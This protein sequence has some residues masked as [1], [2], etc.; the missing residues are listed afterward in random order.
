MHE[1]PASLPLVGMAVIHVGD[2]GELSCVRAS[3]LPGNTTQNYHEKRLAVAGR[4]VYAHLI[5]WYQVNRAKDMSLASELDKAKM[6]GFKLREGDYV[7]VT[8]RRY[9]VKASTF[10]ERSDID[11]LFVPIINPFNGQ[12]AEMKNG[13]LV[14]VRN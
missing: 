13:D 8:C 2:E 7:W 1:R 3:F 9:G 10:G 11:S 12:K 5:G 6:G 14:P 4:S